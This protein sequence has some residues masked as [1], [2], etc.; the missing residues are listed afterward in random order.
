MG[1]NVAGQ[2]YLAVDIRPT[3]AY[4]ALADLGFSPA[5]AALL[6]NKPAGWYWTG[7]M[8]GIAE[9]AEEVRA[10]EDEHEW[11]PMT[12]VVYLGSV[13]GFIGLDRE[14]RKVKWLLKQLNAYG[15]FAYEKG[16]KLDLIRRELAAE[17]EVYN[18]LT[19]MPN[20]RPFDPDALTL[21]RG[22]VF[23]ASTAVEELLP[24]YG[25]IYSRHTKKM[26]PKVE[27]LEDCVKPRGP[28]VFGAGNR[29]WAVMGFPAS[30]SIR[31]KTRAGFLKDDVREVA[32][33]IVE[34][35]DDWRA[36]KAVRW[37]DD[38]LEAD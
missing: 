31:H 38:W 5:S 17:G 32:E 1:F 23:L 18:V 33:G 26:H 19:L 16:P 4:G 9:D 7:F 14:F 24:H 10:F 36:W 20:A 35:L 25:L 27:G 3:R 28:T 29:V 34:D 15:F 6:L 37:G 30:Y 8:V 21:V 11:V 22:L 12:G 2:G 13:T